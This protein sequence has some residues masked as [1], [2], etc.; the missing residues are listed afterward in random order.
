MTRPQQVQNSADMIIVSTST[1]F[2]PRHWPLSPLPLT[3]RE[4][5]EVR[6][7]GI[8]KATLTRPPFL[9]GRGDPIHLAD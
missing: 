3:Q 4:R 5:T 9:E 7:L 8:F 1:N 2:D 6:G